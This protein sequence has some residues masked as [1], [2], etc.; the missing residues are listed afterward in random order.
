DPAADYPAAVLGLGATVTTDR[1]AI[2]ADDY[3][4]G[5]FATALEE[6]EIIT[7][8]SFPV[9]ARAG[10]VKFPH[11]ASRYCLVAVMVAQ[12][13]GGVRVAVTG[14][15]QEGVFRVPAMESA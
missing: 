15:G 7:S 9:P 1:R 8:V 6:G 10:Y 4:Q 5:L 13:A 12:G 2:A 14:A 11:P 3:F